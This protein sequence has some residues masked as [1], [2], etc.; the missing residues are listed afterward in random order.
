VPVE[1]HASVSIVVPAY[2]EAARLPSTLEKILTYLAT[3]EYASEVIVVDDGSLDETASIAE[4]IAAAQAN[5]NPASLTYATSAGQSQ[6]TSTNQDSVPRVGQKRGNLRVIRNPHCGKAYAVRTG[7]L[8]A[9][10]DWAFLCDADLSMPIG[11]LAKF[12]AAAGDDVPVVIGSREALGAQQIG[13]P[14]YRHLMGRVFNWLV[15]MLILGDFQDTQCGFKLFRR[16]VA[17]T[18]F[19]KMR[20]Y[21]T[22]N[23]VVGPMVTGFDVE[24]LYLARKAGHAVKEIGVEWH[25]ASGSQVRPVADSMRMFRDIVRVRLNDLRGHYDR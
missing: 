9:R 23:V 10:S 1:P 14:Y 17:Q 4:R 2:N 3:Q 15:R 22:P 16:D 6:V 7:I 13:T 19:Q 8:A 20:L 5:Q 12:L 21:S 18:L 25:Y 24:I 11:E